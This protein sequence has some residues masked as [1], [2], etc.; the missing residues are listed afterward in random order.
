MSETDS[1][2]IYTERLVKS[3]GDH[4]VVRGVDLR[5]NAGEIVG[6]L[7]PNGGGKNNKFLYDCGTGSANGGTGLF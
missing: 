1:S 5:V 7:G 3:Y 4:A 6:L 2:L